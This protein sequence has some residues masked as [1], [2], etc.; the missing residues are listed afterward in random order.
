MLTSVQPT[1]EPHQAQESQEPAV[2]QQSRVLSQEEL[3]SKVR[4]LAGRP[5]EWV[6]RVR[7]DSEGRWYE[8]IHVDGC[9]EIWLISWLPEHSTGF[10]DHGEANGAFSVVWGTL[11][12]SV[13]PG[14]GTEV[15]VRPVTQGVV[16]AFGPHYVHDVSNTTDSVAVSIHAYSPPLTAMTR[17][18]LTGSGLVPATTETQ[19]D[20]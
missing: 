8:Q 17:Y 12:E 10:H 18:R 6:S 15:T 9:Y 3:A 20:W 2:L 14:R 13:V 11:D 1:I 19:A 16:R 4:E 7:L 5:A